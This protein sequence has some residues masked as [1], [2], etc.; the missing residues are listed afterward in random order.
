[1][2]QYLCVCTRKAVA[3]QRIKAQVLPAQRSSQPARAGFYPPVQV[4][5]Q[6]L[7]AVS[8]SVRLLPVLV[9]AFQGTSEVYLLYWHTSTNTDATAPGRH[10]AR[11]Y[12]DELAHLFFTCFTGTQVQILTLPR[13]AGTMRASIR[14][15]SLTFLQKMISLCS[16]AVLERVVNRTASEFETEDGLKEFSPVTLNPKP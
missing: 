2:R 4:L 13:L 14:K 10:Y 1:V 9:R 3:K 5:T 15:S 7:Q 12:P 8:F 6:L 16:S 11:E